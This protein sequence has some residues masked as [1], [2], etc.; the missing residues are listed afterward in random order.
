MASPN[1]SSPAPRPYATP[2]K[3]SETTFT[4]RLKYEALDEE[5]RALVGSYAISIALGTA[6]LLFVHLK[7][8]PDRPPFFENVPTEIVLRDEPIPIAEPTPPPAVPQEGAAVQTP[9]PGPR[10]RPPGQQG[11]TGTPRQG[12]PGSRTEQYSTGAIGDAFGT[13]S[14]A[15]TGGLTGD[16]SNVLRGTEISSGSGGTGGGL[17]GTGGGGAGGKTVIGYG[18]GGQGA[19]TPGRGG[20]GGGSGTGGGGGGGGIGGVGPGG[21]VVA[22]RVRVSAPAVVDAPPIGAGGRDVS[23]LGTFVRRHEA[24]LRFCYQ[25]R[26]LKAN[27]S[28]A[29]TITVAITIAESGN[30]TGARVTNRT[31]SGAGSSEAESCMLSRIRGWNFPRSEG[32]AGT[33]SFPFNFT[34]SG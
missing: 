11:P 27:P 33:Y 5:G 3:S 22:S 9:A 13:G 7:D 28:L 16:V 34:R 29:G 8:I 32:G 14:G 4:R 31:W 17:G 30:V 10:T 1:P 21:G 24:Q 15:G 12:R 26:G 25:E 6:F 19:T 23:D 18:Q 2:A 20:F